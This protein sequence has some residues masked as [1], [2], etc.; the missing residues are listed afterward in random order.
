MQKNKNLKNCISTIFLL[1]FGWVIFIIFIFINGEKLNSNSKYI[2]TNSS[3]ISVINLESLLK[4]SLK[5]IFIKDQNAKVLRTLH[6]YISITKNKSKEDLGID[7]LSNVICYSIPYKEG[8]ILTFSFN[9]YDKEL[10]KKNIQKNTFK[11]SCF[12]LK[13]DVGMF[14]YYR[15]KNKSTTIST[16]ELELYVRTKLTFKKLKPDSPKTKKTILQAEIIHSFFA[17][18]IAIIHSDFYTE[19]YDNG[20]KFKGQINL[21]SVKKKTE[22]CTFIKPD[23][24]KFHFQTNYLPQKIT[25][26]L[27]N[28]IEKIPFKIPHLVS[29]SMNYN[30]INFENINNE[31]ALL[32]DFDVVFSTKTPFSIDSF[33]IENASKIYGEMKFIN[34][35]LILGKERFYVKQI[36]KNIIYIG[37]T[38]NP[39]FEKKQNH[40]VFEISGNLNSLLNIKGNKFIVSIVKM[41]PFYKSLGNFIQHT[42][43][44]NFKLIRKKSNELKINGQ[45]L[46]KSNHYPASEILMLILTSGLLEIN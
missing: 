39:I 22:N 34:H 46:F 28:I 13:E 8:E 18:E 33:L 2:A 38:K 41:S 29:F 25:D 10:F 4:E 44:S 9:L 19:F 5:Q 12:L 1:F 35:Q 31:L 40:I 16:K 43:H 30:G 17:P 3:I 32:P 6:N 7:F 20:L 26:T 45:L 27:N 37:K 42:E 11:N 23:K 15:S 36:E 24:N 21:A 14:F